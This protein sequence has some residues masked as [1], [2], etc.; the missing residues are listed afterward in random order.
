MNKI[1]KE[2]SININL[3][4]DKIYNEYD[5]NLR[6][7]LLDLPLIVDSAFKDLRPSYIAEYVYDICGLDNIFYQNNHIN[8][9]EEELKQQWL[10]LLTLTNEIIKQLLNLL[11][12]DIPSQM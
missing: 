3:L 2:E 7:K 8:G 10:V 12:I 4:N 5:R 9:S 6:L 11:I 1:I